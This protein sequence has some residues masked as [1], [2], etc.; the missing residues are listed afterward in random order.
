MN[1]FHNIT[2]LEELRK[3]YR[4]LLIKYHP[5]NNR[6]V[7]TTSIIQE[8]NAEY[9]QLFTRCKSDFEQSS[10]YEETSERQKQSYDVVKDKKIREMIMQLSRLSGLVIELC[11]VWLWV[12]GDTISHKEELKALGL[13]YA[14]QKKSWYIHYDDFVKYGKKPSSMSYIRSKYGS[15]IVGS[16]EEREYQAIAD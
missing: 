4:K 3:C 6:E 2:S 1:W 9:D 12:S 13:H 7:D 8:I 14:R 15:V 10:S 5:D 11:G 16:K